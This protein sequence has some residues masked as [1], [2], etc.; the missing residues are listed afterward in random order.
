MDSLTNVV[1]EVVF[2][3]ASDG[4]NLRTYPLANE[5]QQIYAVNVVDWP[6]RS[7]PAAVVVLARVEGD[8]VIIEEDLTDRPLVEALVRAGIPREQIIL[9]YAEGSAVK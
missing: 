7:R 2:S 3:Y 4:L 1:K 6:E 9:K 8:Q 5:D